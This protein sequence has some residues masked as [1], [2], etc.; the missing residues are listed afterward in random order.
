MTLPADSAASQPGVR[1]P[2]RRRVLRLLHRVGPA[3]PLAVAASALPGV[4]ALVLYHRLAP[5]AVWLREHAD[6]G[7]VVC[8]ATFGLVGGVALLPTYAL[9]LVCGWAFG[10][11]PGLVATLGGF[12][13]AA[14]MGYGLAWRAD[15]GRV[16]GVVDDSPKLR[17]VHR[18]LAAGSVARVV[19]TVALVRLAPVAPFSLTN[20]A[21]AAMRVPPLPYAIGT[22]LGMTPRTAV[23]V[24]T[25]SRLSSVDASPGEDP[26]LYVAGAAATVVVAVTLGWMGKK[27]LERSA[28]GSSATA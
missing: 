13:A 27:G 2:L 4:G 23:L 14:M 26:S 19:T 15:R 1:P 5:A 8:A 16:M 7:P 24:Y 22:L 9:S 11:G 3:G 6:V 10:F 12:L 17:A 21:M 20:L 28:K 18:T 25:A